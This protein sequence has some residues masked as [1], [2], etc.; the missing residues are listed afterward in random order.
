MYSVVQNLQS[1]KESHS[2]M[3]TSVITTNVVNKTNTLPPPTPPHPHPHTHHQWL[4]EWHHMS[5]F[6]HLYKGES[7]CTLHSS[8]QSSLYFPVLECCF[9]KGSLRV[10]WHAHMVH[11]FPHPVS[12]IMGML[13]VVSEAYIAI[14]VLEELGRVVVSGA[15]LHFL[16]KQSMPSWNSHVWCRNVP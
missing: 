3:S 16:P 7:G 12:L 2:V 14:H 10:R 5:C 6:L 8:C 1:L 4:V 9:V 11:N 15:S 13:V